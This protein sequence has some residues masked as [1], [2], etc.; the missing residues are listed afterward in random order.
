M[1]TLSSFLSIDLPYFSYTFTLNSLYFPF[2]VAVVVVAIAAVEDTLKVICYV[3]P[4]FKKNWDLYV[5]LNLS[6][7]KRKQKQKQAYNTNNNNNIEC[8]ILKLVL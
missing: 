8:T 7:E 3:S 6:K 1:P 5:F 4:A 2:H